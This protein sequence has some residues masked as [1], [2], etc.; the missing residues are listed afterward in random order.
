MTLNGWLQIAIFVVVLTLITKPM[1]LYLASVFGP[2]SQEGSRGRTF[3]DPALRPV[4]RLI[5][6]LTRVNE[7]KEQG[8]KQYT[9][10]M[11]IFTTV[12]VLVTYLVE[13]IQQ[14]LPLNPQGLDA[15][16]P[17][18]AF[19]TAVSFA[20]NTNWQN[21]YPETTMSYFTTT[22]Q[23]NFHN[24]ISPAVGIVLAVALVRGIARREMNTLGNFWVDMTRTILYVLVPISIVLATLLLSQGVVQNL[25]SYAQVT[26]VEGGTQGLQQ[27]LLA[28]QEAIKELGNNGGGTLNANSAHP[29]ENPTPFSDYLEMLAI[30]TISSGL[31][32]MLGVMVGN[33]RQGWAIYAAVLSLA[34]VGIFVAYAAE[35]N[36]NPSFQGV[37]TQAM[38]DGSSAQAGGNMEGKEVRFGIV[39][40][41]MFAT[42]TTATSTGAVN[43]MHDS[44]T[45]IGG[46]VPLFNI[47]VGEVIFGGAGAGLYG[48]LIFVILSVFIAG[49]MVGRTPEFLGKKIE[50][51]EMKLVMLSILVLEGGILLFAA[52][53]TI[54]PNALTSLANQ[55]PHGLSEILY[56]YTSTIGNNGSAFAGLNGNTTW[57][58]TTLGL[59]TLIGRFLFI[60]PVMGIAGSLARKKL[61]PQTAGTFPTTGPLFVGLLIGVI[62]IVSALTFFPAWALGPIVEHF[63]MGT[64]VQ[65]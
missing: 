20:T 60:V 23:L 41:A 59:T 56:A 25:N 47:A 50:S 51:H 43:S 37:N 10:S 24:F 53:A 8:W 31:I 2:N 21:Y 54:N 65:F 39:N 12:T 64:G 58:N 62:V 3:L 61:V 22:S 28:S 36:G 14:V 40:S 46:L 4:E 57:F 26:T 30:L 29:Y 52:A 19:N 42:I 17:G 1:G 34:L 48:V 11:L 5:Y 6:R 15:V 49:L 9:T 44:F 45:P 7:N 63:L 27:G 32:Y 16:P 33:R 38:Q 18:L 13:R 55:G 35:A